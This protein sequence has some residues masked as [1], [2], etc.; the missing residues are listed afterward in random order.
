MPGWK[1]TLIAAVIIGVLTSLRTLSHYL[2]DDVLSQREFV[3]FVVGDVGLGVLVW[4]GILEAL[5]WVY[6]RFAGET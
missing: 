3:G 2:E 1:K 5:R 6:N 4:L